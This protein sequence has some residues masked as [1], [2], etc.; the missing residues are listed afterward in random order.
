MA[1]S[2]L[3]RVLTSLLSGYVVLRTAIH[4]VSGLLLPALLPQGHQ[5]RS[6]T[7]RRR[8]QQNALLTPAPCRS[9]E[10]SW[11]PYLD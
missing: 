1:A 9:V 5:P 2:C 3:L 7:V 10:G 11:H 4:L 6:A 8:S